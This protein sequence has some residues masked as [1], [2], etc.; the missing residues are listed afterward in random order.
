MKETGRNR[1]FLLVYL[2][3]ASVSVIL[4]LVGILD[5]GEPITSFSLN[6]SAELLGV[7]VLYFLVDRILSVEEWNAS[8]RIDELTRRLEKNTGFLKGREQREDSTLY[9]LLE[10]SSDVRLLG[11]SLVGFTRTFRDSLALAIHNGA[12]IRILVI[13]PKSKAA[14]IISENSSLT[15]EFQRDID[16]ARDYLAFIGSHCKNDKGKL[17]VKF[18][19]WIPSCGIVIIDP[20]KKKRYLRVSIYPPCYDSPLSDRAHFKLTYVGYERWYDTYI[21]QF[22]D[23][24][25]QAYEIES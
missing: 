15:S 1:Y 12:H 19:N 20:E 11:Y 8:K 2:L 18:M 5:G 6:L 10:G 22:E 9:E 16:Q 21:K 4:F 13:D 24:W 17:E 3:L 7:C 25:S 23:L 14:E